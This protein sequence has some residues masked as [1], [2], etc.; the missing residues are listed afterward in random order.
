WQTYR[1]PTGSSNKP[2]LQQNPGVATRQVFDPIGGTT[3]T[4]TYQTV[5]TFP[6]GPELKN[7]MID[8]LGHKRES[9]FSIALDNAPT[10]TGRGQ[11]D[12]YDY[13]LPFT[14]QTSTAGGALFL[15][16]RVFQNLG[17]V[18]SPTYAATPNRSEY[19]AWERDPIGSDPNPPH[20][21]NSNRRPFRSR[22]VF[23]DDG[24]RYAE[25]IAS[26]FDGLGHYR[27]QELKGSGFV[28]IANPNAVLRT[29]TSEYNPLRGTY[30]VDPANNS[31]GGTF[32]M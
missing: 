1:F 30:T 31:A 3:G 28:G 18:A 8:P 25:S 29:E 4:W 14:R 26:R 11:G 5:S 16:S 20:I 6:V 24:G 23:D 10:P 12:R 27:Q 22:T 17:T 2:H 21:Y 7:T 19:V 13:S 32:T 9:Y 15:S